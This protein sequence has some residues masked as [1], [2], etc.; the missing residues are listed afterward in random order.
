M[1]RDSTPAVGEYCHDWLCQMSAEQGEMVRVEY[2]VAERVQNFRFLNM[3]SKHVEVNI[4]ILH[5]RRLNV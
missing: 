5:Q 1:I 4:N 3:Y 2:R